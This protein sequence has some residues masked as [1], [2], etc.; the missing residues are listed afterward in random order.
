MAFYLKKPPKEKEITLE[1]IIDIANRNDAARARETAG[2]VSERFSE[3]KARNAGLRMEGNL[4]YIPKGGNAIIIGDLHGDES[5]LVKILRKTDFVERVKGGEK[6]M[7]IFLGDYIDR[8]QNPLEVLNLVLELKRH[9]PENVVALRGNHEVLQP[10]PNAPAGSEFLHK[11]MGRYR[12]EGADIYMRMYSLFMKLPLAAKS[13]NGILMLHGGVSDKVEGDA[14]IINSGEE[15]EADILWSDPRDIGG[16]EH[17][18]ERGIGVY[19]GKDALGRVLKEM[20]CDVLIRSH[21]PVVVGAEMF[22]GRLLTVFSSG[23]YGSARIG[24]GYVNLENEV[25]N[26]EGILQEV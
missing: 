5:S 2:M 8:G 23:V 21:E 11:V 4:A 7:L 14:S 13:Q 25:K 16:T 22:D 17:N 18:S 20:G 10:S 9:F 15:V 1:S 26:V 6:L 3:E 12:S 24:Y 19:F